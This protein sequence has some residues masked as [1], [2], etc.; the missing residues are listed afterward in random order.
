MAT[1]ARSMNPPSNTVVPFNKG[2]GRIQAKA[3]R[4]QKMTCSPYHIYLNSLAA[5]GRKSMTT[6]LVQCAALLGHQ[7]PCEQF[8]WH[9]L[10][11]ETVHLVRSTLVE[12]GYAVST[13][14]MMLAGLRG[15]T[16]AAF[17]LGQMNADDMLRINA[18]KSIKGSTVRTGRRLSVDETQQLQACCDTI[19]SPARASRERALLLIGI[20]A[21]LR[22]TEICS[23]NLNDLDC[24]QGLLQV[25][26][27]KGR[28]QR[29]IYLAGSVLTAV[30]AWLQQR[31]NEP[32]ALFT[33][34]RKGGVVTH[35][36]LSSSGLSHALRALQQQ[37][38]IAA[39][40]PHD[41]RRTF[42]TQLLEDGVDLNT[43]RQLAGHSDVSTTTRY[44]KRDVA[45]QKNASQS[46]A[47]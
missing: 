26:E 21:G 29:Q 33:T 46:I 2:R 45:W 25:M 3:T 1:S 40:T 36:R 43:V 9:Q 30:T 15:V 44:D 5:S 22:C 47:F 37:A 14:N 12:M 31:G 24:T 19:E 7:G 4:L 23:L 32:G 39:F 38:S 34:I 41:M 35:Q 18:V 28:K 20:G 42:I 10:T 17:N 16:K 8:D 27:G 13:I 6:L 11:F